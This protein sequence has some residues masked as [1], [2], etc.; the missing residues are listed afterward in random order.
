MAEVVV[1]KNGLE[2]VD[3]TIVMIGGGTVHNVEDLFDVIQWK[4]LKEGKQMTRVMQNLET[5]L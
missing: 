3:N 2:D 4:A 5:R 1:A